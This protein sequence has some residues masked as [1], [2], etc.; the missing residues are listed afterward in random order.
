M[1]MYSGRIT[2]ITGE[3][4]QTQNLVAMANVGMAMQDARHIFH[5]GC[6][7]EGW[8]ISPETLSTSD[9]F[10]ELLSH[11]AVM[12]GSL[13]VLADAD[14]IPALT[15]TA[16]HGKSQWLRMIRHKGLDIVLTTVRG[17]EH[18]LRDVL[19]L[20]ETSHVLI[21]YRSQGDGVIGTHYYGKMHERIP[22]YR[23]LLSVE[24]LAN[25]AR[26]LDGRYERPGRD[27]NELIVNPN[28]SLVTAA[29][30]EEAVRSTETSRPKNHAY[31]FLLTRVIRIRPHVQVRTT[32]MVNLPW[33]ESVDK[34]NIE[35]AVLNWLDYACAQWG[36]TLSDVAPN[37]AKNEYPDG[38]GEGLSGQVNIEITKVQPAWPSE[39]TFSR[40]ASIALVGKEAHPKDKPVLQ[41]KQCGEY[42]L[43]DIYDVHTLPAHDESHDWVCTYPKSM[44]APDW[45]N[46][47]VALP[48]LK[49]TQESFEERIKRAAQRKN[50]RVERY[51]GANQN[52][53]VL[54]V[55]GFPVKSDWYENISKLGWGNFD[56]VFAISTEEFAGAFHGMSAEVPQDVL[57]IKCPESSLHICYHPGVVLLLRRGGA[58]LLAELRDLE[59]MQGRTIEISDADGTIL[60]SCEREFPQPFTH[61]DQTERL[62]GVIKKGKEFSGMFNTI[63]DDSRSTSDTIDEG[64]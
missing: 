49:L 8:F 5:N 46:H 14:C 44:I 63:S 2:L 39:A 21:E 40:L 50:S 6:S 20:E 56:G 36:I 57:V 29:D 34:Y 24:Y 54:I 11:E 1:E 61:S 15:E 33:I 4:Q 52:W 45:D 64:I 28:M 17:R 53:L 16:N 41:C 51:D 37:P 9:K 35:R 7:R 19:R 27:L 3:N 58:S 55:E 13:F 59:K 48:E 47:I 23:T 30:Y 43:D 31:N 60:A 32:E 38:L 26:L 10:S 62:R 25:C 18:T 42:E 12:D 22:I